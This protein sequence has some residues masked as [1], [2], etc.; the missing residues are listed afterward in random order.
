M[1]LGQFP[2]G[3]I[4]G[5]EDL[6]IIGQVETFQVT[7]LS[8]SARMLRRAKETWGDMQSRQ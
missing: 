1:H 7:V 2:K 5:M 6:E 3:L 4:D 8:R